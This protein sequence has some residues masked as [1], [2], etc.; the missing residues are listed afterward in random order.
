MPFWATILGGQPK[1]ILEEDVS[2]RFFEIGRVGSPGL[3]SILLSVYGV[4]PEE[5]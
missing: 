3:V 2:A 4:A 1:T 5:E